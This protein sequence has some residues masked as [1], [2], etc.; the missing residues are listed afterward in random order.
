[1]SGD[2]H[3]T[4]PKNTDGSKSQSPPSK[5]PVAKKKANSGSSKKM[6]AKEQ[7]E[8]FIQTARDLGVDETGESFAKVI[9][10]ILK[11]GPVR[12]NESGSK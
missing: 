8:R 2:R 9:D 12:G 1:M 5:K 6:T 10:H 7:S 3:D 11:G 4:S